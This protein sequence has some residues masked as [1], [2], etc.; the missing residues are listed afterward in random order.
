MNKHQASALAKS[1]ERDL[2][3]DRH[4]MEQLGEQWTAEARE[5]VDRFKVLFKEM[6]VPLFV[7]RWTGED[8]ILIDYNNVVEKITCGKI[9]VMLGK[10]AT[11][12]NYHSRPDVIENIRLC[13]EKR[14]PVK[15]EKPIQTTTGKR[16]YFAER[17]DF[18]PPDMV[19][20]RTEDITAQKLAEDKVRASE[21]ELRALFGV[22][23]DVIVVLD[24]KGRYLKIAPTNPALMYRPP[25]EL[26]GKTLHE[27]FPF[28]VA[29][30]FMEYIRNVLK[31][32]KPINI[33]YSLLINK[34]AICFEATISP[35]SENQVFFIARDVTEHKHMDAQLQESLMR[36]SVLY[37]IY[38]Q[39]S[40]ELDIDAL[41]RETLSL[42]RKHLEVDGIV[43]YRVDDAAQDVVFHSSQGL[44]EEFV[45]CLK[46]RML[47]DRAA[48]SLILTGLP[49]VLKIKNAPNGKAKTIA[50]EHG[51][52]DI[53]NYPL[54]AGGKVVG[55]IT[56]MNKNDRAI[57]EKDQELLMAICSHLGTT[58]QNAKLFR[59]FENELAVRTHVKA[60]LS[61]HEESNRLL[62]ETAG[63]SVLRPS[64]KRTVYFTDQNYGVF[65]DETRQVVIQAQKYAAD[66]SLPVLIYGETGTGK[67]QIARIIHGVEASEHDKKPFV[68]I[69][70][71]AIT[72]SLFESE[73]FGYEPGA[74]TGGL[75]KGRIGK[76]ELAAG[77]TLFLD[78]I[79]EMPLEIQAKLLRVIQEKEFYRVGGLKKV[80]MNVRIVC[81]T[82][83]NLFQAVAEGKFRK[84]LYYRLKV[85]YIHLLPLRKRPQEIIP[86]CLMFLKDFA[87]QKGKSFNTISAS[88]A[89][90]LSSYDWPGNIRELRNAMD[91]VVF[92]HDDVTLEP[93][94]L[95]IIRA[96]DPVEE[97][98][99]CNKNPGLKTMGDGSED[100]RSY[101]DQRVIQVLD[102]HGGNKTAA[103]RDL[104]IS[105]RAL[106]RILERL[107]GENIKN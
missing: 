65:S 74:F 32:G 19:V 87:R 33:E 4:Y 29:E 85:G 49:Q 22:L 59:C 9:S 46:S 27:V 66:R 28:S 24:I 38:K 91:W 8:F 103:A 57:Q 88:A 52:T 75:S 3:Q 61:Q 35:L 7:W 13:F 45:A 55:T 60:D 83:I 39:T 101:T 96:G 73:L 95:D 68:D 25:T 40:K 104:G 77:G 67:E 26:L 84:D 42:L 100:L 102:A 90:M 12:S 11:T 14:T 86:L 41:I 51:L 44:P 5:N 36:L 105:R 94:H 31:T 70:C 10:P 48:S 50:L 79:S 17:Y 18:I 72:A 71:A 58:L 43:F 64:T 1:V 53:I 47:G 20:L 80:P 97:K 107:E 76:F 6:S 93:G 89:K 92:M 30:N 82:N 37:D 98:E 69:N 16:K 81:T 106:Y 23:T 63:C 34:R 54:I 99:R 15:A 78:E 2:Q 62:D 21:A 56:I